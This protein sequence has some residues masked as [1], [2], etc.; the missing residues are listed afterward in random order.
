MLGA[1]SMPRS[2]ATSAETTAPLAAIAASTIDWSKRPH[3]SIRRN[4]KFVD[5]SYSGSVNFLLHKAYTPNAM[6]P[7]IYDVHKKIT[8]LTPSPCP[9][10]PD[11]LSG[12]P[13]TV[14]MKYTPLS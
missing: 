8:F 1:Q 11:P 5:I 7:S 4:L 3:S 10:A 2:T 14:D 13:H 6:G 9:H 12:R